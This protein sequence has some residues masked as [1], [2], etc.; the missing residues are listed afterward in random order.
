MFIKFRAK[1]IIMDELANALLENREEL[2]QDFSNLLI[3]TDT[4]SKDEAEKEFERINLKFYQAVFN[5]VI[6]A[7]KV[8]QPEFS[9]RFDNS[10]HNP[11]WMESYVPSSK[12]SLESDQLYSIC[13]YGLTGKEAP[14]RHQLAAKQLQSFTIQDVLRQLHLEFQKK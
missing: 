8:K 1:R 7:L 14:K 13:Y 10:G 9:K 4:I 3:T 11:A 5:Q 6:N 12:T 2:Y